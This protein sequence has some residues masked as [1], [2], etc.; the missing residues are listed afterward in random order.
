M[1]INCFLLIS[2]L[3]FCTFWSSLTAQFVYFDASP[4]NTK[5]VGGSPNF[6]FTNTQTSDDRWRERL[7]FGFDVLNNTG[8]Y[9]KVAVVDADGVMLTTLMSGLNPGQEY[10]VYVLFLSDT[11]N[12]WRVHAGLDSATLTEFRPNS[13]ANRITNLGQ[14]S[15]L[16]SNRTQ[17]MGF[18]GNTTTD[19]KGEINVFID[20]T[21]ATS[22]TGR[23]WYEG[24]AAGAPIPPVVPPGTIEVS[25]EGA[26]TWFN[27]ERS[28]WHGGYLFVG[29]VAN[30][31]RY[32]VTRYD[33]ASQTSS[34]MIVST[35]TSQGKDDHNNPSLIALPN[36]N[37]LAV[38][39]GHGV[40]SSFWYRESNVNFP[41][42]NSDW[43]PEQTQVVPDRNTY[44]NTH[45]LSSEP[46]RI[47]NFHRSI[48][49]NPT[50]TISDDLGATW[51]SSI[52]LISTGGGGIRPYPKYYSN[53]TDR[54]DLIYTNGHPRNSRNSVYHLFYEGGNFCQTDGT[55][56]KSLSNLPLQHDS[57]ERGSVVY[58]YSASPWGPGEGPDDYIPSG[59]AWTWDICYQEN[60]E[61]VCVFQVQRDNV[62]GSGWN[63][64][65]I[66]YYY[67]RWT[68]SEWERRFIAQGGRGIYSSERDY[69]GGMTIDPENPHVVYI[70]TNAADPFAIAD[71]D[72]VPLQINERYEL[73][74]GVTGDG[75]ETFEWEQLT[76]NSPSDHLRPIVTSGHGYDRHVLWFEGTYNHFSNYE[77]RIL[78]SSTSAPL[79]LEGSGFDS[80]GN[81]YLDVMGGTEG[82]MVTST[83]DLQLPFT[84]VPNVTATNNA[85]GEV[86]R[87]LIPPSSQNSTANFFRVEEN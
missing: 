34:H 35:N 40:E 13:P 23:S 17:Y 44:S 2:A 46:N 74:R 81:F 18:L 42:Q 10:A 45:H 37:I 73:Y 1:N 60:G 75:G 12:N 39:A 43:G 72:N 69:G 29:Y 7:G 6:F 50:L 4:E 61:P 66:Y 38:Y 31:G 21:N 87:F 64:D 83:A 14:T 78:V 80:S 8:I 27:D 57:G 22:G 20:D 86:N 47:F 25:P 11:S 26:W 28:I 68:G 52:Q 58:P 84:E 54:I 15:V 24:L 77:T 67:A 36:G 5:T 85:D 49:F 63:H 65:R 41:S 33:P 79:F 71:L 56:V 32:G 3:G 55:V 70:S 19:S 59:R 82:R 9:E 76:F 30:D 51:N 62:T 16:G 48:N 53:K